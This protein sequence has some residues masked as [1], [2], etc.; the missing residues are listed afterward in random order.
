MSAWR[1]IQALETRLASAKAA[2]SRCSSGLRFNERRCVD[3]MGVCSRMTQ[4]CARCCTLP[5]PTSKG[6]RRQFSARRL[7]A[8]GAVNRDLRS[9]KWGLIGLGTEFVQHGQPPAPRLG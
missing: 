5:Q 6:V 2:I 1:P 3:G 4:V 8:R 7:H 9:W